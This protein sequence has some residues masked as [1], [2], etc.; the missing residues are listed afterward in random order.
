MIRKTSLVAICFLAA[1]VCRAQDEIEFMTGAKVQGT[2]VEIDKQG[3]KVSIETT[4]AGRSLRR[5]FAYKT[6]HAV[7]YR[8]K[9]YVLTEKTAETEKGDGGSTGKKITRNKTQIRDVIEEAGKNP[10]DWFESTPLD[11]PDTLDLSWQEPAPPPWNNRKN[12]GQY[13]W[14]VINP[15]PS[16][17]RSGVK[18]MHHLMTIHKDD[19]RIRHRSMTSMGAMY[20]R[21]FQD[22]AHAAYWWQQA[23]VKPGEPDSVALA[24]CFWRLGNRQMAMDLLTGRSLRPDMIKLWSDM[25]ETAKALQIAEVLAPAYVK[26][27]FTGGE[28]YLLAGDA[29]R[30][31]GKA[32]KA[33]ENYQKVLDETGQ[34]KGRVEQ[35]RKRAQAA[36]ESIELFELSDVKNV[37]DG[38]YTS[39]SL[40]YEGDLKVEVVIKDQRIESVRVV[41]HKEK[42][43]YSALNDVPN[44]I[45]TKQS[46][47]GVDAT[48][49]ATITAEAIIHATAKVLAKRAE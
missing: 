20:F 25:G 35:N 34:F 46:V 7:T 48:S 24:E 17:W 4:V 27:G 33:I 10:P 3:K 19:E 26:Q 45:I 41:E 23:G 22:Y 42:Q 16:R 40:G 18:L 9:R 28:V 39:T 38:T 29:C 8:E 21:F 2:I 11:F 6:I 49:R 37:A 47:R 36:I 30:R 15:N 32:K 44:Q 1:A 13:I 5:T 14:D 43:F 12:V 31:D